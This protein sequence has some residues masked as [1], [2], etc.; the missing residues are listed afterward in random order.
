MCD[1]SEEGDEVRPVSFFTVEDCEAVS[2]C[3]SLLWHKVGVHCWRF[4][5]WTF[6]DGDWW[7]YQITELLDLNHEVYRRRPDL[8]R[9][10][11]L[12]MAP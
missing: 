9:E 5:I 11:A 1:A 3:S 7:E 10:V 8:Y 6:L 12:V 4:S 2:Y